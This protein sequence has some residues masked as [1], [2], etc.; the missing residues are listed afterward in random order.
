MCLIFLEENDTAYV[1]YLVVR[2]GTIVQ[3]QTIILNK[4]LDETPA[5]FYL[6]LLHN[7]GQHLIVMRMN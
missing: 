5:E 3:T 2:N 1:N 6:L 7:Y 4:K